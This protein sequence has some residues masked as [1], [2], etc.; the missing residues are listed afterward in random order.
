MFFWVMSAIPSI[1][2]KK[3]PSSAL[4]ALHSNTSG[5]PASS[6]KSVNIVENHMN[7]RT[8]H[9]NQCLRD[10]STAAKNTKLQHVSARSERKQGRSRRTQ[11][12]TV[13]AFMS[14]NQ[15]W[16]T[17]STSRRWNLL[18]QAAMPRKNQRS[19]NSRNQESK[20]WKKLKK[21]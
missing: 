6:P 11:N 19:L 18:E 20:T 17:I 10:V 16:S 7:Q 13:W 9:V 3:G 8:S 4:T 1:L 21:M 15:P 5:W 12:P 2:F 14:P